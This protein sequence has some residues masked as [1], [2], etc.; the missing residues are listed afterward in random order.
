MKNLEENIRNQRP[1]MDIDEPNLEAG[2]Q[3]IEQELENEK[4]RRNWGWLKVAAA[5]V[6]VFGAGYVAHFVAVDHDPPTLAANG[7]SELAAIHPEFAVEEQALMMTVSN[8]R[9]SVDS[10]RTETDDL[11]FLE[12][13]LAEIDALDKT[14]RESLL[15]EQDQEKILAR[16]LKHYQ[17]KIRILE[18]MLREVKKKNRIKERNEQDYV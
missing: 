8:L 16:I 14:L 10:V 15:N 6:I 17:K 3:A 11:S 12:E 7:V 5:A 18:R 2:W 9:A 1:W 13:E 4:P